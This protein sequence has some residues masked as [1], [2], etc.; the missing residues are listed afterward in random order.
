VTRMAEYNNLPQ[1]LAFYDQVRHVVT[2]DQVPVQLP[3]LRDGQATTIAFPQ[4]QEAVDFAFDLQLRL[5]NPPS[6]RPDLDNPLKVSSDGRTASLYPPL[7]GLSEP[8]AESNRITQVAEQIA[9]VHH[10]N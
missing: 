2:R 6:R 1:C 5:E 7:A 10:E 8:P 3:R 4:S 9:R